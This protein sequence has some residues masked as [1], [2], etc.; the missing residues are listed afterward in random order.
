[1]ANIMLTQKLVDTELSSLIEIEEA[2]SSVISDLDDLYAYGGFN[3]LS[4]ISSTTVSLKNPTYSGSYGEY[5]LTGSFSAKRNVYDEILSSSSSFSKMVIDDGYGLVTVKGTFSSSYSNASEKYSLSISSLSYSG[6]DGS[7]WSLTGSVKSDSTGMY[8]ASLTGFSSTDADGNSLSFTGKYTWSASLEDYTGYMT[9][10]SVTVGRT[11]L[12]A[13]GLK[14]NYEEFSEWGDSP[15]VDS[16][17]PMLL[18][19]ND[20]ITVSKN[21]PPTWTF[22]STTYHDIAGYFGSDKITGTSLDE[23]LYGDWFDEQ[24]DFTKEGNDTLLGMGGS[25]YLYGGSGNDVLNGGDGDDDLSGNSGSDKLT[26][27]AGRDIFNFLVDNFFRDEVYD[28]SVDTVTDF[29]PKNG[30]ILSLYYDVSY[31]DI[32]FYKTLAEAK[33]EQAECFYT[34]GKIYFNTDVTGYGYTPTPIITLVGKPSNYLNEDG[35]GWAE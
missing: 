13:S 4:D 27:G 9:S 20:V 5:S 28:K 26:G 22:H 30:D 33:S 11:K 35:D 23:T 24:E 15:S 6:E 32:T 18:S 16:L 29:D 19:G 3:E 7:K 21:D 34:G 1:M 25:D 12:S 17:L 31:I 14:I 2:L 10:M 8:S